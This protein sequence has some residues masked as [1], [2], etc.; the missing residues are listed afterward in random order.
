M[1]IPAGPA[2]LKSLWRRHL[3]P[4]LQGDDTLAARYVEVSG[5]LAT[6]P[7]APNGSSPSTI[8]SACAAKASSAARRR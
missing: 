5:Q 2:A 1:V 6:C 8:F 3:A 7:V 4:M